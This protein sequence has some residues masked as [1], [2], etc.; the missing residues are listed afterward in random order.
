MR[1][2]LNPWKTAFHFIELDIQIFSI[3]LIIPISPFHL[4]FG[5][6]PSS[7]HIAPFQFMHLSNISITWHRNHN[8]QNTKNNY[9]INH[10]IP[11]LQEYLL[12]ITSI[13]HGGRGERS[14]ISS[15]SDQTVCQDLMQ[16]CEE[17]CYFNNANFSFT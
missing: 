8:W 11:A 5:I 9:I 7:C 6:Y 15:K 16:L 13:L 10:L 4:W 12:L 14:V 3:R 17:L 1:Y 2:S